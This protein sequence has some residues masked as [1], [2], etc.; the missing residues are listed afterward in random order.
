MVALPTVDSLANN[1]LPGNVGEPK[2]RNVPLAADEVLIKIIRPPSMVKAPLPADELCKNWINPLTVKA[3]ERPADAALR[4]SIL[5]TTFCVI[6]ELLVMPTPLMVSLNVGVAVMVNALA[7]ALNTMPF[8][9]VLAE[10]ETPVV[11]ETANVAVSGWPL[12][13]V[14][15]V[16][17]AAVFQSP[18]VGFAFHVA[19]PAKVLLVIESRSRNISTATNNNGNRRRGRGQGTAKV[20]DEERHTVLAAK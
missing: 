13:T 10:R 16:Q 5:P 6:P 12:G 18:E 17:F 14:G 4:K 15:G 11:F 1:K 8:T 9:S 20:I 2:L 19:L 3:V 7:P